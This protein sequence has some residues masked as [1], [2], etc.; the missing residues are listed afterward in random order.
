MISGKESLEAEEMGLDGS[1]NGILLRTDS[2]SVETKDGEAF[3][4]ETFIGGIAV[5]GTLTSETFAW[6]ARAVGLIKGTSAG[7]A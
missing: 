3:I 4:G 2:G 1:V 6:G 7:I 5:S